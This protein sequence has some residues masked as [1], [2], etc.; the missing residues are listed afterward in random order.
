[1]RDGDCYGPVVNLAARG[2][3]IARTGTVVVSDE[4]R[5]ALDDGGLCFEPLPPQALKGF[6]DAVTMHRVV[7]A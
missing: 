7:R 4:L 2:V 5:R 3:A 6:G 1:V